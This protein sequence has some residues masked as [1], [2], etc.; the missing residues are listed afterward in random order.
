MRLLLTISLLLTSFCLHAGSQVQGVRLWDAPDHARL[1]FD[2][3]SPVE[4]KIFTLSNPDR[5]VVDPD[6]AACG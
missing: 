5:L 3:A 1:V 2:V 4:H 6:T